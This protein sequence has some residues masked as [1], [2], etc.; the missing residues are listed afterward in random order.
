M[1]DALIVIIFMAP[2]LYTLLKRVR[3]LEDELR[4]MKQQLK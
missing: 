4:E 2:V 1:M 3:K